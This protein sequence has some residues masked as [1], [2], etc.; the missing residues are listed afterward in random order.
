MDILTATHLSG[1]IAILGALMYAIG[2]VLLL[3]P[4]VAPTRDPVVVKVD[5]KPYPKLQRRA[6]LFSRMAILPWSRLAWGGL[7]GVFATPLTLA[8]L[9]LVYYGLSPAGDWATLPPTLL[10]A[11]A[12][13]I[14]PF[15][16]G[17]FIYLG[18]N[19]QLLHAV[20]DDARPLLIDVLMRQQT[21][22]LICYA[23]LFICGLVASI[24]FSVA[25]ALGHTR[26][27]VWLAA[28]NPV[29]ATLA[30]LVLKRFLPQAVADHTEGA[31]FNIAYIIFFGL[32]TVALW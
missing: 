24:W 21:V 30:W 6:E 3:A 7:L 12:T 23:V 2:D 27:P 14:G 4:K 10:F 32:M 31:G 22:M 11:I 26:F 15:I 13:A 1:I 16:H 17:S 8:G 29:S 5:L 9:W 28:V 20:N 25:V 19:V 18:E